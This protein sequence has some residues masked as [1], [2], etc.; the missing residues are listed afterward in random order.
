VIG[1]RQ[2][3]IREFRLRAA[4]SARVF[5]RQRRTSHPVSVCPLSYGVPSTT[6]SWREDG[7]VCYSAHVLLRHP[8]AYQR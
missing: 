2:Y 3:S 4:K 5:H 1:C 6:R 7:T 8:H